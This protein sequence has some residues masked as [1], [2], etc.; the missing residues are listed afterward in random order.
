MNTTTNRRKVLARATRDL[1]RGLG[2]FLLAALGTSAAASLAGRN[3]AVPLTSL[4]QRARG[5]ARG[6]LGCRLEPGAVDG[7]TLADAFER[8]AQEVRAREEALSQLTAFVEYGE[9]ATSGE[10]MEG[11]ITTWNPGAE[12]LYGYTAE[13]MKGKPISVLIPPDR[14]DEQRVLMEKLRQGDRVERYETVRQR[15]NGSLVDV[16]VSM[17]PMKDSAGRTVGTAAIAHDISARKRAEAALRESEERFRLV[18]T[19]SLDTIFYQGLDLR[20]VWVINP[21][22]PFGEEQILGKTDFDLFSADDAQR[23]TDV[24]RRVLDTGVGTRSEMKL[25][26]G[27]K[28]GYYDAVFEPWRDNEG[29][30]V[31]IAGYVRDITERKRVEGEREQ[32]L[33]E[34]ARYASELDFTLASIADGLLIYN[35]TGEIIRMNAAAENTL[36]YSQADLEKPVLERL[37]TLHAETPDGTPLQEDELPPLRALRGETVRGL[38]LV[39]HPPSGRKVWV[40]LSAAPIRTPNGRI[41]G[42]VLIFT[43]ITALHDLQEEQEEYISL[44]SHDLRT[45]LTSLQGHAQLLQRM[46][47][48]SD[49]DDRELRSVEA[50]IRG[51]RRMNAMIQDLVDTARLEAGHLELKKQPTS[52]EHFMYGLLERATGAVDAQRI[53]MEVPAGLSP[54]LADPNRL[55]RIVMNLLSNALKYSPAESTVLVTAESRDGEATVSIADQGEGI[56]PEDLPHIFERFYRARSAREAQGAGLGLYITKMLVEAH[57]GRIWVRSELGKGSTFYFTLPAA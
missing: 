27:D 20:Y 24:K 7:K 12:R 51:A 57:G 15:K 46:L 30:I 48:K 44:I 42:A 32:L 23:L 36:G 49:A 11:I 25:T 55:E 4:R 43:D 19:H 52:L 37:A 17:S 1:F 14:V 45:P 6:V 22:L 9:D 26:L 41:L 50:I 39:I 33:E 53:R 47:S 3:L 18:A 35:A 8:M 2:L 56:A 40:S 34:L 21:I 16:S 38:V 5:L 54:V 10:T 29:R 28:E 13:E 31:G